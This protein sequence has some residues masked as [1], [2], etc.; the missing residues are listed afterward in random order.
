MS[1]DIQYPEEVM[2]RGRYRALQEYPEIRELIDFYG[3]QTVERA[4]ARVLRREIR[5][6]GP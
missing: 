1:N 2:A 6:D 3:A 5:R 4:A